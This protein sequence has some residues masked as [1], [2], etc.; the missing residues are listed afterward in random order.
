MSKYSTKILP[1]LIYMLVILSLAG[2]TGIVSADTGGEQQIT[3]VAITDINVGTYTNSSEN[4]IYYYFYGISVT[5]KNDGNVPVSLFN[6]VLSEQTN[7]STE[8][9]TEKKTVSG[10]NPGSSENVDFSLTLIGGYKYNLTF[11]IDYS[12][13][14]STNN[15]VRINNY[16]ASG[17]D[18]Y[19]NVGINGNKDKTI[20]ISSTSPKFDIYGPDYIKPYIILNIYKNGLNICNYKTNSTIFNVPIRSEN[21]SGVY[22]FTAKYI[23]ILDRKPGNNVVMS[24]N[25]KIDTIPPNISISPENILLNG[26]IEQ[27]DRIIF[28]ANVTDDY[29]NKQITAIFELYRIDNNNITYLVHE[30]G[31][32]LDRIY[33]ENGLIYLKIT[34][35]DSS[36]NIKTVEYPLRIVPISDFGELG[37]NYDKAVPFV[38]G[39]IAV[40]ALLSIF[41]F[42][43]T[44]YPA[45][46]ILLSIPAIKVMYS[47]LS[48]KDITGNILREGIIKA[49]DI[50]PGITFIE[51]MKQLNMKNGTLVYHLGILEREKIIVTKKD[52]R[53]R[54]FYPM[55]R[56]IPD[57]KNT[58][59]SFQEIRI[60][61]IIMEKPGINTKTICEIL[62]MSRQVMEHHLN[63]LVDGGFVV[64]ED[65][66]KIQY[67]YSTEKASRATGT[68][69][70]DEFEFLNANT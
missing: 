4:G 65:S 13:T 58:P 62:H 61:K 49:V 47:K 21:T 31:N 22:N 38:T 26:T 30:T 50:N 70:M 7:G 27:G 19:L 57:G 34:A 35:I 3:D 9:K 40:T 17:Y 60:L 5:I 45:M 69:D 44:R 32:K 28:R 42:E 15:V 16:S 43:G 63:G 25:Y 11:T 36:N 39:T 56:K 8:I 12:D 41:L 48:K 64:T 54:R 33:N 10:I 67:L 66:G 46:K 14:N 24:S 68:E 37:N 59:F 52:G 18:G 29:D 55:K 2:M 20:K 53:Y 51:I 23:S 1:L 6:M